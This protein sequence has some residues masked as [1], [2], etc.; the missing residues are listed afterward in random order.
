MLRH[1][2]REAG[3]AIV[4]GF[5]AMDATCASRDLHGGGVAAV[6]LGQ[7]AA[8]ERVDEALGHAVAL[9]AAHGRAGRLQSNERA[10]ARVSAAM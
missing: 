10:T 3:S 1:S 7:V 4:F 6:H 5:I 9:R 8:L 2:V